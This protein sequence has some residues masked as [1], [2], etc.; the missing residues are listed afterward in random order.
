MRQAQTHSFGASFGEQPK[1]EYDC[2]KQHPLRF[3]WREVLSR[4]YPYMTPLMVLKHEAGCERGC[5][6]RKGQAVFICKPGNYYFS[7]KEKDT[8]IHSSVSF[9]FVP[10]LRNAISFIPGFGGSGWAPT[11]EEDGGP[12]QVENFYLRD[13][14]REMEEEEEGGTMEGSLIISSLDFAALPLCV[15]L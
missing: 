9:S 7:S 10:V 3:P 8:I 5:N 13:G 6:E 2:I 12:Q 1:S 11:E 15:R 4:G 14:E